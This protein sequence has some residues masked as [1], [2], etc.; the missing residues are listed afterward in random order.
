VFL[1]SPPNFSTVVRHAP[2]T[3]LHRRSNQLSV[4]LC[5]MNNDMIAWFDILQGN[6]A[7]RPAV[8]RAGRLEAFN[9]TVPFIANGG[10]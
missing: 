4:F 10:R 1:G 8:P 6:C 9:R 3:N 2:H 7:I 5:G